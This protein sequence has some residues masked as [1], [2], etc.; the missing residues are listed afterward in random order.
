MDR[1]QRRHGAQGNN[2]GSEYERMSAPEGMAKFG[3]LHGQQYTAATDLCEQLSGTA[4]RHCSLSGRPF[5]MH[6]FMNW[7]NAPIAMASVTACTV[8]LS[9]PWR[10][11]VNNKFLRLFSLCIVVMSLLSAGV[12]AQQSAAQQFFGHNAAVAKVQPTWFTPVMQAD[13]RLV[14]YYRFS[15]SNEFGSTK[16]QTT[17]YGNGRGGGVIGWNRFEFDVVPA[18]FIQHNSATT[19]GAGDTSLLVKAR[20]LSS[21][22]DKGN[23]IL[24]AIGS[25]SFATGTALNGARTD[26]W[27]ATLAGGKGLGKKTV[28][29]S[30]LEFARRLPRHAAHLAR[31]RRQRHL[32]RWRPAR[33]QNAE[34]HHPGCLLYPAQKSLEADTSVLYL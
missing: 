10:P 14:Q 4:H 23:Y 21:P 27:T 3:N 24:T 16:T 9:I 1:P 31:A 2:C 34:L 19:D 29:E 11:S 13:P 25:H 5:L 8:W 17:N 18:P 7:D 30:T 6:C 26:T 33:R 32:L 22:S 20:L 28:V 15:F 12:S